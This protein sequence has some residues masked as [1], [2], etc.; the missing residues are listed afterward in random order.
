MTYNRGLLINLQKKERDYNLQITN[1]FSKM[2][3]LL[4][5]I[6]VCSDKKYF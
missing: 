2:L 5:L 4:N 3:I 1:L 6:G